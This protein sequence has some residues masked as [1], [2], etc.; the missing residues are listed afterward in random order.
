MNLECPHCGANYAIDAK[1]LAGQSRL[2]G[3]C[4]QC[5]SS[6]VISAQHNPG[7]LPAK[8]VAAV[9]VIDGPARGQV[10]RLRQARSLLGRA[11]ADIVLRDPEVSRKHCV[12]EVH[13]STATLVDL[14]TTNGTYV[15]GKRI[16]SCKLNHLAKFRVG[17][18]T[19]VFT[20]T[21]KTADESKAPA[22]LVA[23]HNRD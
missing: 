7:R 17:A 5:N 4:N 21:N 3:H 23:R 11:G 16:D 2:N 6:F 13:G 20:V 19:L 9:A 15:H 18:S 10:F 12:I 22:T 8:Q 14:D 1:Q